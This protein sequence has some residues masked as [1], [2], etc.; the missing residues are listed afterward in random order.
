MLVIA[1]AQVSFPV[2]RVAGDRTVA[3]IS[4]RVIAGSTAV[5]GAGGRGRSRGSVAERSYSLDSSCGSDKIVRLAGKDGIF[6]HMADKFR[7]GGISCAIRHADISGADPGYPA[8]DDII[9]IRR[10][11]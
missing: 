8:E 6:H 9:Q 11:L 2:P 1:G 3:F 10:I 5:A 7:F 4:A